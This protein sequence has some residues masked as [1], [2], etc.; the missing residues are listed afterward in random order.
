VKRTLVVL[1][2]L[3]FLSGVASANTYTVT[4]TADAGAGTLRQAILDANA[5]PG[6]DTIAFAIAG[7]GVHLITPTTALPAISDA[8]TIDGYTQAG[9][10]ANTNPVGQGLNTV[11]TIEVAGGLG[12][13][14]SNTTI[15]GLSIHGGG[16]T[17]NN[18]FTN[19]KI[20]G[21]FLGTDVTGTQRL[22]G[23]FG[24]QVTVTAESSATIGGPTPAARN[25]IAGCQ[26]GIILAGAGTGNTVQGNMVGL[27]VS[28]DA[29]LTSP[30]PGTSFAININGSGHSIIG[31]VLAGGSNGLSVNG[32]GHA[33]KGN[34]VGTDVTGTVLF[35][36]GEHGFQ[37]Q[38]TNHVIGGSSPGDGNIVAGAE[39]YNGLELS[40][41][42]HVV[43]G[44]FIGT[45]P[46]GTIDLGNHH[47]GIVGIG[48]D[49]TIGGTGPGEGNAIAF[50]ASA[51]YSGVLVQGAHVRI[52]GNR[53]YA[54]NNG[55]GIDLFAGSTT[56][57]T[58]NDAGDGDTGP[59]AL[60]NF[61]ILTTAEPAA[62]QGAG[63]HVAGVLNSAP[64][65]T[66]DLDFYSNPAC[67]PRPQEFL[68]GQ[69]YIGSTQVTTDGSGN[70]SFDLTLPFTVEAGARI[71]ATATDPNGNTSEFSQR[72]I[73]SMTPASGP[74]A[75]GTSVT[76]TGMLF[77][78][79]ATVTLG[80]A[81]ASNVNVTGPTHI[82][83]AAPALQAGTLNNVVVANTDGTG[84][85]LVNGWVAD[86]NDVPGSQQFYFHVTKLVSNGITAGCG[87]GNYCPLSS[88]TR[89][90]MAV[91]LLKA[92]N[93]LCYVPPPC[94]GIFPDVPCPSTFANWIEA[95]AAEGITGGCGG[96]NYC[97]L[98]PVRRDQMA[99]FLLKAEHGSSY[100]PPACAGT[101]GDVA[102]PS[103]FANWIEQLAAENITGGCGGGNYCP[104]SN[105]TRGQMA[106]FISKTFN[107]Q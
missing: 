56:G 35:G 2:G 49:L 83:A 82:T 85:T 57:V 58:P 29:L 77:A 78:D 62:P 60:Q 32:T 38:G 97:P 43:Y 10:S 8:V 54:N 7:S 37:V 12:V 34:F 106:V 107:L 26:S 81:P 86:F 91:F 48:N 95:L 67:A 79:G 68:E 31:N 90:Q 25:L 104:L 74:A 28:G 87:G 46:S 36:I 5:N 101:F 17:F 105:N 50:N 59:N 47:A 20:E 39:F 24:T 66:F 61:P 14:A 27:A 30:C 92:K 76:L 73:F 64:S 44:N 69:D 103:T 52:R 4:S 33:L 11:L 40:G 16:V 21:C 23:G 51:G 96:G 1:G 22:D 75:G 41:S 42:G 94:T 72:L 71:S 98:S 9:S 70:A 45:D 100:V 84:G 89:Q 80:G 53:I 3:W 13:S 65:T 63:T 99:V 19:N 15:R 88:V 18:G 55:L 93:G 6:A 102:C